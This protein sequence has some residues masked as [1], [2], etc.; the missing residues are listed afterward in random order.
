MDYKDEKAAYFGSQKR[1]ESILG[2]QVVKLI[3]EFEPKK[4][5][6]KKKKKVAT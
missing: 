2:A 6:K 5:K 4:K 1:L 3:R